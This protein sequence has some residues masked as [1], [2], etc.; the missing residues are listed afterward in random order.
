[1]TVDFWAGGEVNSTAAN[2]TTTTAP[3]DMTPIRRR[4]TMARGSSASALTDM[5]ASCRTTST[6]AQPPRPYTAPVN[7]KP[8]A[9]PRSKWWARRG[10][11][12]R[13]RDY[14]SP[15]L[16]TELQAPVLPA[17]TGSGA[18]TRTQNPLI[19]SQMLCQL[20]YPGLCGCDVSSGRQM[21]MMAGP[22]CSSCPGPTRGRA[23][24]R[25]L[26]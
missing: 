10:S 23:R 18:G 1:M 16:T 4:F 8:S 17:G 5:G 15:A 3:A 11:N 12:P 22:V 19:N 26:E 14:E 6:A 24:R 20:S 13:P 21:A 25:D 7:A 2:T 9:Y